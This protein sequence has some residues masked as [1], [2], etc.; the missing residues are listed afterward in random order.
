M[1]S[2]AKKN[3]A[4]YDIPQKPLQNKYEYKTT[5]IN[6]RRYLGSKY[7]LLDFI[8]GVIDDECKNI[9]SFADIFAGT[10]SVSSIF[11]DRKLIINDTLYFNY[12]CHIAWFGTQKYDELKIQ[13]LIVY[14]NDTFI[15]EDNY[16][17]NTFGDT[18]FSKNDCRK[19][20]YIRQDIENRFNSNEINERER[21]ILITSLLYAMDKIANTCGHYDAYRKG[22]AFEKELELRVPLASNKNNANNKCFNIDANELVKT[23]SADLVYIDPPYNSRQYCDA[24]HLLENIAKWEK[25][26][27]FGESKKMDRAKLKSDYCS[28]YATIAFENLI[29]NIKAKYILLSY[30]NMAEKGNARSNAKISDADIMRILSAKGEVK[31]FTENYKVFSAGK[32][33]IKDNQERLFLCICKD[34]RTNAAAKLI[35]SPLNYTGGKFKLLSQIL[36]LFPKD[37]TTFVDLFCGGCSIGLNAKCDKVIFNDKNS[38]LTYIYNTFKN[39]DKEQIFKLINKTIK[40]FNLSQVNVYGYEHYNCNSADGLGKYNVNGYNKLRE[41][42]NKDL[43]QDYYYYIVL[44]VLIIYAF[45][46]QIR[47]NKN[48]EFNLPVGKRDFNKSMQNKLSNFIDALQANNFTFLHKDFREIDI[49]KY[50]KNAFVYADPPYLIATASYNEQNG[51]TD[52]DEKELLDYLDNLNKNGYRF[53]LSNILCSKGKT[54]LILI[55]WIKRNNYIVH[56]LNKDY[57]NC[58]YHAKNKNETTDEVLITNYKRSEQ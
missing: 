32:T 39:L 20:G 45:N 24:Y 25:P 30:N 47:F 44:Y 40:D 55:D 7:K 29:K 50:D 51:W 13:E 35:P 16:V 58:N 3:D 22:V 18:F 14:Y 26:K 12:L 36:P 17:S 38:H 56:H 37:I 41:K 9:K 33:D 23:I 31:I 8:K 52:K 43:S 15:L 5:L 34:N 28:S 48:G 46:N 27:V 42:F 10:G 11:T 57:S 54:N 49:T 1:I 53:A 2:S 4:F 19:I 21:A 6:N